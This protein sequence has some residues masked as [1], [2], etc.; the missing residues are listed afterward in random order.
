MAKPTVALLVSFAFLVTGAAAVPGCGSGG[1]ASSPADG[2]GTTA[3]GVDGGGSVHPTAV[4]TAPDGVEVFREVALDGRSSVAPAGLVIT[5]YS[6]A[7]LE[8]P[9]GSGAALRELTRPMAYFLPDKA[10]AYRVR[11]GV[12]VGERGA[13]FA[14]ATLHVSDDCC[15][16]VARVGEAMRAVGLRETLSLDGSG[17]TDPR[18]EALLYSW[19]LTASPDASQPTLARADAPL[20]A[21]T[22]DAALPHARY[23]VALVVSN[24]SGLQSA[25]ARAVITVRNSRPTLTLAGPERLASPGQPV[26]LEAQASDA[27]GD[28]LRY[29]WRLASQPGHDA[30][31]TVIPPGV[32]ATLSTQLGLI[33]DYLVEC[34]VNDGFED[35]EVARLTVSTGNQAPVVEAGGAQSVGHTCDAQGACTA[36]ARLDGAATDL[37]G[38]QLTVRWDVAPGE[39]PTASVSFSNPADAASRVTLTAADGAI[40]GAY[41]LRFCARD[42]LH[43]FVCDTTTLTVSNVA[44]TALPSGPASVAH[45][46]SWSGAPDGGGPE[47]GTSLFLAAFQLRGAGRDGELQAGAVEAPYLRYT[48]SGPRSGEA[49]D[50]GALI[51]F[52]DP[53]AREPHITLQRDCA[54]GCDGGLLLLGAYTFHLDVTDRS[55]GIGSAVHTVT[56]T[57]EPPQV[58]LEGPLAIA[59]GQAAALRAVGTDANGDPLSYRWRLVSGDGARVVPGASSERAS[60]QTPAQGQGPYVAEV[61]AS[62][63]FADSAPARHTLRIN[64]PP[65]LAPLVERTVGHLCTG[66]SPCSATLG[67]AG[68]ATD[69]ENDALT[70]RWRLVAPPERSGVAATFTPPDAPQTSL[71]LRAPGDGRVSTAGLSPYLVELCAKDALHDFTCQQATLTVTN[72]PPTVAASAPA[73]AYHAADTYEATVQLGATA[74]DPEYAGSGTEPPYVRYE[75][76][77]P[78][79]TEPNVVVAFATGSTAASRTPSVNLRWACGAACTARPVPLLGSYSFSVRVTDSEGASATAAAQTEVRNRVPTGLALSA[80]SQ[81]FRPGELVVL[82]AVAATDADGD[83][84]SYA[85]TVTPPAGAPY[86]LASTTTQGRFFLSTAVFGSYRVAVVADDGYDA[87]AP[88]TV[89]VAVTNAQPDRP[90]VTGLPAGPLRPGASFELTAVGPATDADGD[91][92]HF[93]WAL[94]GPGQLAPAMGTTVTMRLPAGAAAIGSYAVDVRACDSYGGCSAVETK[95]FAVVNNA[96]GKPQFTSAPPTGLRPGAAPAFSITAVSDPEGDGVSY[97]WTL[98]AQCPS[99]TLLTPSPGGLAASVQTPAGVAGLGQYRFTVSACDVYGACT[100]SDPLTFNVVNTV[101]SAPV[102]V[103]ASPTAGWRPGA[104]INLSASGAVDPDADA[105]VYRWVLTGGPA[106]ATLSADEGATTTLRTVA[107]AAGLGLYTL[108][109]SACDFQGCSAS[110]FTGYNLANSPPHFDTIQASPTRIRPNGTSL[111]SV[112]NASDP[113]GDTPSFAWRVVSPSPAAGVSLR[114]AGASATLV[115][116]NA[117]ASVGAYVVAV[118]A[119]DGYGACTSE[120]NVTVNVDNA[121]PVVTGVHSSPSGSAPSMVKAGDLVTLT[122]DVSDGDTDPVSVQWGLV[123]GPSEAVLTALTTTQVQLQTVPGYYGTYRVRA[124][125]AD[126][127]TKGAEVVYDLVV[128]APPEPGI[129]GEPNL[130]VGGEYAHSCDVLGRCEAAVALVTTPVDP[131]HQ[132]GTFQW[133]SLAASPGVTVSFSQA[134]GSWNTGGV[135]TQTVRLSTTS[136]FSGSPPFVSPLAGG[137][138]LRYC[139]NDTLYTSASEAV[140]TDLSVTVGNAAPTVTS[141]LASDDDQAPPGNGGSPGTAE[142]PLPFAHQAFELGN[143]RWRFIKWVR[144]VAKARDPESGAENANLLYRWEVVSKADPDANVHVYLDR[145]AGVGGSGASTVHVAIFKDMALSCPQTEPGFLGKYTLRFR[146]TDVNG[147]TSG[148][149]EGLVTV[150]MDN[151]APTGVEAGTPTTVDHQYVASTGRYGATASPASSSAGTDANGDPRCFYRRIETSAPSACLVSV[152]SPSDCLTTETLVTPFPILGNLP[153]SIELRGGTTLVSNP[154]VPGTHSVRVIGR[155]PWGLEANAVGSVSVGNR[156]P[157][158][159]TVAF[160]STTARQRLGLGIYTVDLVATALTLPPD[161]DGD[162]QSVRWY[163]GVGAGAGVSVTGPGTT[164][165]NGTIRLTRVGTSLVGTYPVCVELMDVFG[166]ASTNCTTV[167]VT[168]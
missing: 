53:Q 128:N 144:L 96:P 64:A 124:T 68:G 138:K 121:A 60:L 14:E 113:E 145:N 135:Y 94:R 103:V 63:G 90:S 25:P 109:V 66:T 122:A 67:Y 132:S 155:D 62:D 139:V 12:Y 101:P 134:T 85:W 27:D 112:V 150:L 164:T 54:A 43:D 123:A 92:V 162:D 141:A 29:S 98:E 82:N 21:F 36:S 148:D 5:D 10:G 136:N 26:A 119:C 81:R 77:L 1:V 73:V 86:R 106:G 152:L 75:W 110:V 57:N 91:L 45:S 24:R 80:P 42:T 84:V 19:T 70:Y 133:S 3:P 100:A 115:A 127:W 9:P 168:N 49:A 56:V 140:C 154:T 151:S 97:A 163:A 83:S 137:Y 61:I 59:A 166:A 2:G 104:T 31:L 111:L 146:A 4:L 142:S 35:S 18:N 52:D 28:S 72:A 16:P 22:P 99:G 13:D 165:S 126:P 17:S 114:P 93:E 149:G 107:G 30:A 76:T 147:A 32:H 167:T 160:A 39:L 58:T 120:S 34:F 143:N 40:A 8:R 129:V 153:N 130:P 105:L 118:K 161:P 78:I 46:V 47:S 23:E 44:P 159:A 71:T 87:S 157:A 79:S 48:W 95:W 88:A 6:W 55:G 11:L 125:P 117:A 65:L 50:P 41:R 20:A 33:G 108:G 102:S 156:A 37:E 7:M 74:A 89:D 38:D 158:S 51:R 69:T 131:E 116:S 15:R